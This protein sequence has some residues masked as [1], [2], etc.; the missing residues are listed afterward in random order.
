VTNTAQ[1][2]TEPLPVTMISGRRY[3]IVCLLRAVVGSVT[4]VSVRMIPFDGGANKSATWGDV[5]CNAVTAGSA[6]DSLQSGFI[7]EGDGATHSIDIR[8]LT[9][10]AGATASA[11]WDW[12]CRFYV[13]DIGPVTRLTGGSSP[14]PSIV[15][16]APWDARYA[17]LSVVA[18]ATATTVDMTLN[19]AGFGFDN[20]LSGNAPAQV[21]R[22][23]PIVVCQGL[24]RRTFATN[25]ISGQLCTVPS[26][27]RPLEQNIFLCQ[28]SAGIIARVDVRVDGVVAVFTSPAISIAQNGWITL[29]MTWT[30]V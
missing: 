3:R 13:E 10:T 23:G 12:N 26:G 17:P 18:T 1:V 25:F 2:I 28:T 30:T 29:S 11:Y 24:L 20:Y 19:P 5:Y 22:L 14:P 15:D 27:Y 4:A 6:F 9:T 7:V 16:W 21:T 8:I